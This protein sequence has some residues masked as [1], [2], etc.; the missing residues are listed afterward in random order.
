MFYFGQYHS[1]S[2]YLSLCWWSRTN[3]Y[4]LGLSESILRLLGPPQLPVMAPVFSAVEVDE[5]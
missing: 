2:L 4:I 3:A 1:L 5:C